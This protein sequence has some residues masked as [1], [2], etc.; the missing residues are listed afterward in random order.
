MERN[1]VMKKEWSTDTFYK[2]GEPWTCAKWKKPDTKVTYCMIPFLGN[3]Q[4]SQIHRNRKQISGCQKPGE[5]AG[6]A[7]WV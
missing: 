6:T 1:S 2:M 5:R 3:I 4:N 7:S